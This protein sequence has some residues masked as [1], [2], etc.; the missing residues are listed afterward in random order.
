[1]GGRTPRREM[2]LPPPILFFFFKKNKIFWGFLARRSG[3][4]LL[5]PRSEGMRCAE[6]FGRECAES[7]ITVPIEKKTHISALYYSSPSPSTFTDRAPADWAALGRGEPL[8]P[9]GEGHRGLPAVPPRAPV[10]DMSHGWLFP[11]PNPN[12]APG[13]GDRL[14]SPAL[15]RLPGLLSLSC[16][17]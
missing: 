7:A 12:E 2:A 9:A 11:F 13:R 8:S 1:M 15:L 5:P 10:G 16:R 3:Q 4:A 14:G 17:F 6:P